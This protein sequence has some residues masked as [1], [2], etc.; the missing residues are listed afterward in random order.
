LVRT[1]SPDQPVPAGGAAPEAALRRRIRDL[2]EWAAARAEKR[3][4]GQ[5]PQNGQPA[6]FFVCGRQYTGSSERFTSE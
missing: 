5:V 1:F 2:F 4:P 6:P 3:S